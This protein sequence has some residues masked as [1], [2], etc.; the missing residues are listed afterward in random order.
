MLF[1]SY[2][3]VIANSNNDVAFERVIVSPRRGIG[4]TSVQS[5]YQKASEY[6]TSLHAA[7]K[8]MEEEGGA[9]RGRGGTALSALVSQIEKWHGM[10]K[11]APFWDVVQHALEESGYLNMWRLESTP[12]AKERLDNI[13]ELINSLS[14][15]PDIHSYLEHISLI[16]DTDSLADENKVNVMTIHAAKGLE[17]TA[18]FLAGWEEGIFPSPQSIDE[19][20]S[21]IEEE[22]RLAYV[23]ITR[24]KRLLYVMHAM[25]RRLY[26]GMYQQNPCSR[27]IKELKHSSYKRY[28]A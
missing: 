4:Q 8:K 14:N 24:A 6:G 15:F 3:K 13:R 10:L 16:T 27:F 12:E 19:K 28:G 18:V 21:G 7:A 20:E 23:A 25:Y 2:M 5:L 9:M 26:G 22:R 17:F 11:D 1:R